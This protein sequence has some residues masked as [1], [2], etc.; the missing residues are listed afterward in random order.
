MDSKLREVIQFVSEFWENEQEYG[1][2][3][4][5]WCFYCGEYQGEKANENNHK[6][7]CMHLKATALLLKD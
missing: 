3:M 1:G 2:R 6:V 5:T 4:E 7:D